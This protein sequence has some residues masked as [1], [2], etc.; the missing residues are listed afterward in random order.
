M[1]S[2]TA[3]DRVGDEGV[4]CHDAAQRQCRN[5]RITEQRRAHE[6]GQR[7]R[8]GKRQQAKDDEVFAP[9]LHA[10]EVHFKC[11][12]EHDIVESHLAEQFER[13]VAHQDV[14]AVLT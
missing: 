14:Q 9:L 8:H 13:V 2:V 3:H 11:R 10:L 6:V 4:R 1:Q 12:E 7:E 5:G